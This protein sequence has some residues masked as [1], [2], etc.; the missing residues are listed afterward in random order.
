MYHCIVIDDENLARERITSFVE[1]QG[2][3]QVVGQT[4]EFKE[5]ES[6]LLKHR[7]DVCFMDINIIGG[8]GI[9][10]ARKLA[11]SLDCHWVFTTA[12]SEYA[13][14]AFDLEATDYLLKP[15]ENS[16]LATVLQKVEKLKRKTVKPSK[17]ILAVKSVGAVEFVN[18]QDIIWIKGSANYVEL[19]CANRMLLHRE[20]LSKLE[21]QLNPEKFIRVH[22]S[23]MVNV[24]KINSLSSELGR[25]SL[26]HLNNGDE[27]KIGQG[28]KASLFEFLG[29]DS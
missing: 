16:R 19:H 26:L 17:S 20:T 2:N 11:K 29:V 25:F 5:A 28:H 9:E 24:D 6:L 22:R 14:Q 10:L 4:G 7:P 27:V 1:E 21:M 15:F 8:S 18:V 3:W 23:A 12:S 13:I